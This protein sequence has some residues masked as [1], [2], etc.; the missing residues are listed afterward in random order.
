MIQMLDTK[1]AIEF[2]RKFRK[3]YQKANQ[4]I[5]TAFEKRLT[6][7]QKDRFQPQLNNHA[8]TGKYKGFRSINVTG[9]WRA[10][11][12]ES[13]ESEGIIT[14]IFHLLGTHSKLYK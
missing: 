2:D 4:K 13:T 8:L 1:M 10:L 3:A 11:F 5:K 14:I 12:S 6:L 9:D 7:F